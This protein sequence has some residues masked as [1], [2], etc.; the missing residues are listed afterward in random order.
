MTGLT[1]VKPAPGGFRILPDKVP[2]ITIA[3]MPRI[4]PRPH[5]FRT[6]GK[7]HPAKDRCHDRRY[8]QQQKFLHSNL[9]IKNKCK[10]PAAWI[11][12]YPKMPNYPFLSIIITAGKHAG[13]TPTGQDKKP[14]K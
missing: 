3:L 4:C 12:K 2:Y 9:P 6:G 13:M 7:K 5:F 8:Q 14:T 11:I 1:V 10:N